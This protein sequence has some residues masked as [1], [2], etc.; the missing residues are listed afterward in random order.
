MTQ[1][2]IIAIDYEGREVYMRHFWDEQKDHVLFEAAEVLRKNRHVEFVIGLEYVEVIPMARQIQRT[3]HGSD[4]S[5][6]CCL[7]FTLKRKYAGNV[8]ENQYSSPSG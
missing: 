1:I 5:H 7:S 3:R 8:K 2:Q 4:I 6:G